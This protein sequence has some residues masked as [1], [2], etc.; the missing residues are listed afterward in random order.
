MPR[1]SLT[2][3][4]SLLGSDFQAR[5][6]LTSLLGVE[7]ALGASAQLRLMIWGRIRLSWLRESCVE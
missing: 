2:F 3:H 7:R 5:V 4:Q 1:I 6:P